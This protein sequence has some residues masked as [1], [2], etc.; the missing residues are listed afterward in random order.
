MEIIKFYDE[1]CGI[2]HKM[3]HYDSKIANELGLGFVGVTMQDRPAYRKYRDII[4]SRY[5]KK[6]GVHEGVG[7]PTYFVMR[8]KEIL[9]EILGGMD[10]GTFRERVKRILD[11]SR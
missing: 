11:R 1:S 4:S 3:S 7:W 5:P 2:C 8:D 9:G 10:K 6:H